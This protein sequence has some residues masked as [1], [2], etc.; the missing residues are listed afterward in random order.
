MDNSEVMGMVSLIVAISGAIIGII[1]HKRI[2]S[3]CCGHNVEASVDIENTTPPTIKKP[4]ENK[5]DII[6]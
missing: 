1:N 5:N 2:R 6:V 4:E 3:R